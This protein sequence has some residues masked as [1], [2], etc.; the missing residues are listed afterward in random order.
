MALNR[1]HHLFG[2][3]TRTALLTAVRLLGETYPSELAKLLDVRLYT[4]QRILASLEGESVL[5][6]RQLGRTRRVSLNPRYFA[7]RELEALLWKLGENDTELQQTL[8]TKRRR[9][10][11][12][13][14][15]AP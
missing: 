10:R 9:P 5:V 4:V 13:G 6:S 8:A 2:S 12:A 7:H 3:Q 11:R 14:K 15:P 1:P